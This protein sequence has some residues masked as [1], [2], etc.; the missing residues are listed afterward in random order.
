LYYKK[1]TEGPVSVVGIA[2]GYGLDGSGIES[3]WRARFSAPVQISPGVHPLLCHGYRVFPVGRG[4]RGVGLTLPHTI[5]CRGPRKSRA[6]PLLTFRAFVVYKRSQLNPLQASSGAYPAFCLVGTRG[7]FLQSL[8][9]I[10]DLH[11]EWRVR[12]SGAVA[13]HPP[14]PY[15]HADGKIYLINES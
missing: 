3:R 1:S 6:M 14:I 8:N 12:I 9:L 2:T 7:I 10:N 13:P 11:I 4:G 5:Q 15:C